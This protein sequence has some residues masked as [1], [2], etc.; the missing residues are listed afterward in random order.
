MGEY[1]FSATGHVHVFVG[2]MR[3]EGRDPVLVDPNLVLAGEHPQDRFGTSVGTAGDV[4]ADGY[5]DLVVGAGAND[6]GGTGAGRV[7][8]YLGGPVV[9]AVPDLVLTGERPSGLLGRSVAAAGDVNGDGFADIVIGAPGVFAGEDAGRAYVV[10]I[11]PVPLGIGPPGGGGAV[12]QIHPN[13]A[14]GRVSLELELTAPGDVTAEVY[15]TGG[16]RVGT[17]VE[18]EALP[19]GRTVLGWEPQSLGAGL[20]LVRIQIAGRQETRKLVWLGQR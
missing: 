19:V 4:N 6:S 3:H 1:N 2:G 13:P 14:R 18:R 7:Y 20:Y 12:I 8:V 15:D 11:S 9:D 16:R 5:S 10:L 17:I